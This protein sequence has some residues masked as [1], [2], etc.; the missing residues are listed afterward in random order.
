VDSNQAAPKRGEIWFAN[1]G[2]L[3][4]SHGAEI[5]KSRPVLIIGNNIINERRRTI[6]VIPLATSGG[7]AAAHPPLTVSLNGNGKQGVA[8]ID[9][10]RALDKRRLSKF[11]ENI[12]PDELKNIVNSVSQ[13]LEIG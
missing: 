6:L 10:L 3:N 4:P 11:I 13:I 1:L 7:K 9:Q 8:V 2:T 12:G 5:Q